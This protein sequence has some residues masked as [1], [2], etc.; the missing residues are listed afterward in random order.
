MKISC[1]CGGGGGGGEGEEN[2]ISLLCS[3]P[4]CRMW[5]IMCGYTGHFYRGKL[6]F[7]HRK[8]YL[9]V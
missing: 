7:Y 1:V 6:P 5:Y 2:T 4:T 8:L 3:S 9:V